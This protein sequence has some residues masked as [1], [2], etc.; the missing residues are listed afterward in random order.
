MTPV[1]RRRP[2]S[3]QKAAAACAVLALMLAAQASVAGIFDDNEARRKIDDTD[4]RVTQLQ[5]DLDLR[6]SVIEQQLKG[7]GLVDLLN[8]VEQVKA[9][10]AR[11]RGQ[12]EV[13]TNDIDQQQKRQRDLYLDLDTRLRK[14]ESVQPA[15]AADAAATPAT[16]VANATAGA[17]E[18][19]AYDAAL[20]QF[21]RADYN[22]AIGSFASFVKTYPQSPLAASA[23]YWVGNAQFARRDFRAAIA[24]QRALIK[25][26]P[27][28]PKVPDAM[29]N[30]ASAQSELGDNASARKTLEELISKFPA[31]DAGVKAKQR[32]AIR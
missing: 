20:D 17:A 4:A 7:Q 31:S 23:Q 2:I 5:H 15:P 19:R 10:V 25:Q 14:I 21:K 1:L 8:Q 30:V 32:L 3:R 13:L 18:Q 12:V 24:A 29:L 22:G 27:D 16:P 28:S 9:D 6:I 11:L 26:Y